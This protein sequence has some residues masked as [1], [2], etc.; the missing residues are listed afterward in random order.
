M[1]STR[2]KLLKLA[3]VCLLCVGIVAGLALIIQ[4]FVA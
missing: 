3:I 4:S 1:E 2:T